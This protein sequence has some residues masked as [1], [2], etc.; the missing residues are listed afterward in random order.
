MDPYLYLPP[1]IWT[2]TLRFGFVGCLKEFYINSAPINVVAY[3][4]EQDVGEF[5]KTLLKA[6][7]YFFKVKDLLILKTNHILK[8]LY[9]IIMSQDS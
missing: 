2:A 4:H 8:R 6:L 9:S 1:A 5:L 7:W 3:A